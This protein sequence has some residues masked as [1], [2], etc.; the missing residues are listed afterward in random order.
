MFY[1]IKQFYLSI[2]A[3][4]SE[5]EKRFAQSYLNK[6]EQDLFFKLQVAE[7]KH[8]INVA[9]DIKN[10]V[11][12]EKQNYLIRLG[13]LHDIGKIKVKLTPVDKG[14]IVILDKLSQGKLRHYTK[15]KKVNSYYNHGEIAYDLLKGM[16]NYEEAFLNQIKHHH[17]KDQED[18]QMLMIL[19]KWDDKN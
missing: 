12:R 6:K 4:V 19:Q 13:L 11:A 5:D 1:R 7:Q 18:D 17:C 15:Y 3:K 10:N 14:L 9:K 8:C 16:G 2:T